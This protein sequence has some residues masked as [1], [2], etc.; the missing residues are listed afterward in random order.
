VTSNERYARLALFEAN[1]GREFGWFVEKDGVVLAALTDPRFED[2][3]WYSYDVEP[4][5]QRPAQGEA[6]FTAEFW[7][8]PGL[9]FRNR[10]TGEVADGAFPGPLVGRRVSMQ[11]LHTAARPTFVERVLLWIRRRTRG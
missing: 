2:M 10:V 1:Y 7:N 6:V 9:V 8:Q 4:V 5:A 3:F 11:R